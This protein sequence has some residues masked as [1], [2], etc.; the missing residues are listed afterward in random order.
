MSGKLKGI[1]VFTC[2]NSPFLSPLKV[3]KSKKFAERQKLHGKWHM[4]GLACRSCEV[5]KLAF[6]DRSSLL[7]LMPVLKK[8]QLNI[9]D[10]MFLHC[11]TKNEHLECMCTP[12]LVFLECKATLL[13]NVA[14]PISSTSNYQASCEPPRST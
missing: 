5:F 11:G 12:Y 6:I 13:D 9:K 1:N 10:G 3:A 8:N 4:E 2:W 14:D 7:L